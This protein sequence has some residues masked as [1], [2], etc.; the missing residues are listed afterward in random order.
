LRIPRLY[1]NN[2]VDKNCDPQNLRISE[3]TQSVTM[4]KNKGIR[5]R[6]MDDNYIFVEDNVSEWKVGKFF[7]KELDSGAIYLRDDQ[8][9]QDNVQLIS[10]VIGEN[11][12]ERFICNIE[13]KRGNQPSWRRN[14]VYHWTF[15]TK[16]HLE[17]LY[18]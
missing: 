12:K 14:Q 13:T 4:Q 10:M 3:E 9:N 1:V 18:S 16:H 7:C 5:D 17:N 6:C 15:V 2:F 8:D 11:Y